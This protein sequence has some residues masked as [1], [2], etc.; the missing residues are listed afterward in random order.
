MKTFKKTIILSVLITITSALYAQ[1][2]RPTFDDYLK[3]K[4]QGFNQYQQQKEDDFNAFRRQANA[5][6]AAK[7]AEAWKLFDMEP[8]RD[9]PKLPDPD[10]PLVSNDEP[11]VPSL[12][13]KPS[14]IIAPLPS[15]PNKPQ[16]R[17]V[18]A[19]SEV[20]K[21]SDNVFAFNF[22]NTPCE[23][24]MDNRL[25]FKLSGV[26]E[27][28]VATVWQQLSGKESDALVEDCFRI[29]DEM[30]LCDW[31]VVSLFKA[32]GDAWL[33]KD[34][35]EATL[36]Q[37][38]LLTQMGYKIRIGRKG[39]ELVVLVAFDGHVYGLPYYKLDSGDFYNI[40]PKKNNEGCYIFSMSFPNE[41]V[42]SLRP[43]PIPV[44]AENETEGRCFTTKRFPEMTVTLSVNR[45]LLDFYTT[46]PHCRWDNYVYA[47]LSDNV[48]G[49]LY[50]IFRKT[51]EGKTVQEAAD[52]FL[53][54]MHTAF[55]YKTD[56]QQFGYERSFFGDELFFHPY[57]DCEDR[58]ILYSILV[59]DLL[60]I[61]V[62]LLEYPEH[63]S[64]AI[65]LPKEVNGS[66]L[67]LDGKR[68]LM[69]DPTFIGSHIGQVADPFKNVQPTVIKIQ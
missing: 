22:F 28:D 32:I 19:L 46:Y 18:P 20:P 16:P 44:F 11:M 23:V 43:Y 29:I 59:R 31:A 1:D 60:G 2:D 48:K 64:T 63:I 24:R 41:K 5:Q 38:Y 65:C 10:K 56:H 51:I 34:S 37:M 52:M 67:E 13:V 21:P 68:Y 9:E 58:A 3:S 4:Q 25:K 55:S 45:N 54:F 50:P 8:P 69:C 17:P 36:M 53:H 40:T 33:G 61:D 35:N 27:K 6:F 62:V 47:G 39:E 30:H 42:V 57:S 15:E 26:K 14:N 12:P 49:R 7:M 66:Y